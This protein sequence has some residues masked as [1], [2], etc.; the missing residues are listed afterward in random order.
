[1]YLIMKFYAHK[2]IGAEQEPGE[3]EVLIKPTR[4]SSFG[5][6]S[7]AIQLS[8]DDVDVLS[9]RVINADTEDLEAYFAFVVEPS[10]GIYKIVNEFI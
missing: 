2:V 7:F 6:E 10:K 9:I 5:G 4:D 3:F 1:M 8:Y